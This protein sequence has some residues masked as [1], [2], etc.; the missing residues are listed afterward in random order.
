M[1]YKNIF[2][3]SFYVSVITFGTGLTGYLFQILMGRMLEYEVFSSLSAFLS[4]I[5]ILGTIFTSIQMYVAREA[6]ILSENESFTNKTGIYNLIFKTFLIILIFSLLL[7]L[8]LIFFEKLIQS[9]LKIYEDSLILVIFLIF[10]FFSIAYLI[11]GLVQSIKKFYF[12]GFMNLLSQMLKIFFFL[13]Y[14]YIGIKNFRLIEIFIFSS[15]LIIFFSLFGLKGKFQMNTNFFFKL[16][17]FFFEFQNFLKIFLT[18]LSFGLLIN[19]DILLVNYMFDSKT[20]SN[21]II[22]SLISKIGLF[23]S[24]GAIS[25]MYPLVSGNIQNRKKLNY[26]K[27]SFIFCSLTIFSI[28]FFFYLFGD[29]FILFFFGQKFD[30]VSVFLI[31]LIIAQSPLV[32][33][34]LAENYLVAKSK[35][36]YTWLIIITLPILAFVI[37]FNLNNSINNFINILLFYSFSMFII[38]YIYIFVAKSEK[39]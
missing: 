38:G 32:L 36:F 8:S 19:F 1:L 39:D 12:L 29:I 14:T 30:F 35:F 21:Y 9:V 28:I 27:Q 7:I 5:G 4:L 2:L 33:I 23:L 3:K 24:G 6:A 11:F 26:F 10:I 13:L 37:Y 31:K 34:H 20:S 16:T 18:N 15:F 17:N 25:V 22:A